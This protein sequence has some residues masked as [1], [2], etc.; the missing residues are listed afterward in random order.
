MNAEEQA[1]WGPE[2][3]Q[4]PGRWSSLWTGVYGD[5]LGPVADGR[6]RAGPV[7]QRSFCPHA[8]LP[9]VLGYPAPEGVA[10]PAARVWSTRCAGVGVVDSKNRALDVLRS[11][12]AVRENS[13]TK[14]EK[15][16]SA[17]LPREL[18]RGGLPHT[19]AVSALLVPAAPLQGPSG[20]A[21]GRWNLGFYI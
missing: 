15:P 9:L 17:G 7:H 11:A 1:G 10:G 18:G 19:A 6:Q 21:T 3:G 16:G 4:N 14:T 2:P 20:A 13:H 8:T 12:S 5:A